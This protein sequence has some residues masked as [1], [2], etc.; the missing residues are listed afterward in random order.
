MIITRKKGNLCELRGITY[1]KDDV[2]SDWDHK[3]FIS[4][5]F[6]VNQVNGND[7]TWMNLTLNGKTEKVNINLPYVFEDGRTPRAID[8]KVGMTVAKYDREKDE[9]VG[10][11]F[12]I[13]SLEK[14]VLPTENRENSWMYDDVKDLDIVRVANKEDGSAIRFLMVNG[15]LVAK[16]KF[17]L[18]AEQTNLAMAVVNN[19]A[20]LKAF[21]LK[22][23]EL[24][25]AAL[26]EI[27]SPLNK[28]VLSY[29][30]TSLRLLQLR[31]EK[32]GEY[33]NIY[34]YPLVKA[35]GVLTANQEPL[36]TLDEMFEMS[37]E[38]ENKEGWVVTFSNGKMAKIKTHWYMTLHG[39]LADGLKENKLVSKILNEEIDDV[40]SFLPVDATEERGFIND[41]TE[42][43][44]S[45]VNKLATEAFDTFNDNYD[46]DRKA[47]A[48]KFKG[49][50][51]FHYM[52]RLFRDN[53]FEAVEKAVVENV[54]YNTRR[55]EMA[56]TY[57]KD[58]GFE[59]ELRLLDDDN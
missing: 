22:T 25:L 17:S 11:F 54:I 38:I 50:P 1:I 4:K 14:E 27:V 29:N 56:R 34:D 55:L 31:D 32:N 40:L 18:E 53:N 15:E 8:L 33:L 19:D 35:F 3:L 36:H 46:G 6:N 12:T 7:V 57:L 24:G 45:H 2:Y 49:T 10:D 9:V 37:S 43:V 42:L 23:L 39:L 26:F 44:V 21:I 41:L 16:T 5:F 51:L 13:E 48:M 47:F 52:T 59:R 30:E 20:N 58:L 28:I